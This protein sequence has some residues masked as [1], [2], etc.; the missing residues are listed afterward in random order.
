MKSIKS[1]KILKELYKCNKSSQRI[2]GAVNIYRMVPCNEEMHK[3]YISQI[4]EI[5]ADIPLCQP[6]PYGGTQVDF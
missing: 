2:R 3:G 6:V 5:L 4:I 1:T